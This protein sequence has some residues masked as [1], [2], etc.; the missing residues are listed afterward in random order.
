LSLDVKFLDEKR[1]E[2]MEVVEAVT[3]VDNDIADVKEEIV[4]DEADV[5]PVDEDFTETEI[6]VKAE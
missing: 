4:V 2:I 3:P 6:E 5:N 1:S